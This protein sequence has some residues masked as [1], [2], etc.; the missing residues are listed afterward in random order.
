[1]DG[2]AMENEEKGKKIAIL[3]ILRILKEK[4]DENH[5]LSQQQIM[6]L[7]ETEYGV[8]INR[9]SVRRNLEKLKEAG[10]PITAREVERETNGKKNA[11]T[12]DWQWDHLLNE[13]ELI[14]LT[15]ALYFSHIP[16]ASVKKLE[17]KIKEI[18]S[19]FYDDGKNYVR[20]LPHAEGITAGSGVRD[21]VRIISAAL[22]GRKKIRFF[23]E[24]FGPDY[25]RYRYTGNDGKPLEYVVSPYSIFA[26]DGRYGL[27]GNVDGET[28]I[29]AFRLELLSYV[30]ILPETLV[31]QKS[32]PET[33]GMLKISEYVSALQGV[34]AGREEVCRF[35]ASL[36]MV[37]DIVEQ[38]GKNAT[39]VSASQNE[40]EVEVKITPQAL[41]SW[42]F[43]HAPHVRVISP[44]ILV[45]SMRDKIAVLSRTY[46]R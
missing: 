32:L 7:L 3:Y 26:S 44:E 21:T 23:Y 1:M 17:K 5:P 12:R 25:K 41:E 34:Y 45:R 31:S 19:P 8:S 38:F 18:T 29:R 4:S 33:E 43:S 22:E 28:G 39:I 40:V 15:D 14:L 36:D 24:Y 9:K 10:F 27:L 13:E 30:S 37:T 20:N 16:S 35:R 2:D 6:N 42:A 11:L 46:N